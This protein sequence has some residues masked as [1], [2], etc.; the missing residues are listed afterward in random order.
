MSGLATLGSVS[1]GVAVL[2]TGFQT[3]DNVRGQQQ[4]HKDLEQR[5][6]RQ[7]TDLV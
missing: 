4:Q 6:E 5:Q 7:I 2:Y 3:V 1:A